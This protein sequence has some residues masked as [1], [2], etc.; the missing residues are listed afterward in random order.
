M[1]AKRVAIIGAGVGALAAALTLA[2][3]GFA[4]TVLERA[5]T[6]GGKLRE[7]EVAGHSI[8]A[9]PTV[10]TMRWVFEQLFAE[11]GL[12]LDAR[13]PMTRA[14]VLAR[15]AWGD[16]RLDLFADEDRSVDAIGRFAGAAQADGYRR[17]VADSARIFR[18]LDA[19]FISASR[20]GVAELV[21]RIGPWRIG[22]LAGIRP[23]ATMWSELGRYFG[24]PRLRQLF[25]RYA[26]Y[27]GSSPYSAP[28]TLMLV[29]HVERE[30]VWLVEGGMHRLARVLESAANAR[31]AVFRYGAD[32]VEIACEGGRA[33]AVVLAGG[34]RVEAN[35]I[36]VNA[37][38][39][40]LSDGRFGDAARRAVPAQ[41]RRG[42]SLSALTWALAARTDGFPLSRHNVFFSADY[43][44]EFDQILQQGRLP[45][46]PTVYVCAQDRDASAGSG[47]ASPAARPERLFCLVNAPAAGGEGRAFTAEELERCKQSAFSCLSRS[48]LSIAADSEATVTTGPDQFAQLFPATGG[49]LYGPIAAGWRTS[50]ARQGSRSR[51]PGL[52]LA[53]GSIH[54][55][56]GVPMAVLSGRQAASSVMA[57]WA[58]TGRFHPA[59]T[60]GG[61][62][63]A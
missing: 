52:Y 45:G 35:A 34:E 14:D 8:D 55:G 43:R 46:Q 2:A 38:V 40:A 23:F 50:F 57:D 60:P 33:R 51:I 42:R 53:G 48:G 12:D 31:G 61:T 3:R 27:C 9:G 59:A 30:G 13:L 20:P 56:P 29:A 4:V 62:A 22:E 54:P 16:D 63:T 21:R 17:F 58:S 11:A 39:A 6:P 28:A 32:V 49:A 10:L 37:D 25:G 44:A 15:H 26:T 7:L 24:D 1:S 41:P 36:V 19:S 5:A 18:T 47:A